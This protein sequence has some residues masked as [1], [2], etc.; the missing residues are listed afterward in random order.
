METDKEPT[1]TQAGLDRLKHWFK[2]VGTRD[3]KVRG[4]KGE[5]VA[6]TGPT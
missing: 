2:K 1:I 6:T 4:P 3:V 5:E